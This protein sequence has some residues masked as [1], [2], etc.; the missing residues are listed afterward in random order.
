[1]THGCCRSPLRSAKDDGVDIDALAAEIEGAGASKET[2]GKKKKKG[3]KKEEFEY[4][5]SFSRPTPRSHTDSVC[6]RSED[7]ILKELEELSLET[8]GGKGKVRAPPETAGDP[9]VHVDPPDDVCPLLSPPES[10]QR[11]AS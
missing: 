8:Q 3:A 6:P 1:M 5:C 9:R 2:K 11:G 4:G 10:R 7:D